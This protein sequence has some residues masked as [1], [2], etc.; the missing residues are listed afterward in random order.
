M[1]ILIDL[2]HPAHVHFFK[3]FISIMK[4]KG[5]EIVLTCSDKDV[6]KQLLDAYNLPYICL[7]HYGRCL[8]GKLYSLIT[9]TVRLFIIA[10]N[11][12]PDIYLGIAPARASTVALFFRKPCFAFDDT[13]HSIWELGLYRHL[14]KLIATP[15]AYMKQLGKKQVRYEGYHALAHLHP[16]Y[17][18]PDPLV[19]ESLNLKPDDK[20]VILRFVSWQ[21]FHD[22]GHHGLDMKAKRRLVNNL[23]KYA[24]VFISSEAN[25]PEEFEP[26]RIPLPPHKFHHLLYYATLCVT[27][28]STTATEAAV[29]G[30]PA[31]YI[32]T[33]WPKLG[34]MCE[35]AEKYELLFNSNNSEQ[36]LNKAVNLIQMSDIKQLWQIK[37]Q[38][39]L[40]SKIDITCFM[41][42]KLLSTYL[43]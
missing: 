25:L 21:A 14:V 31:I 5:H 20:F 23:G 9:M 32:S 17:F 37:R 7:G 39:M 6:T 26:Y 27:E 42:E 18:M 1:L 30:T 15:D 8:V 38:K 4:L 12:H 40:T 24:R 28:G 43:V 33:L 19:L 34:V 16:H 2:G 35:L 3:H 11:T 36:T 22:V 29:L 10:L 41:V 13:E